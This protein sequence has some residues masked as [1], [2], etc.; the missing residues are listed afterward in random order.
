MKLY[1]TVSS[2]RTTKGQGGKALHIIIRNEKQNPCIAL[3]VN[4][5]VTGR[6]QGNLYVDIVH[7]AVQ[8]KGTFLE[9]KKGEKQKGDTHT[10]Q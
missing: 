8:S 9:D 10:G 4:V 7:A 2:E 1:A 3:A 6:V 5:D